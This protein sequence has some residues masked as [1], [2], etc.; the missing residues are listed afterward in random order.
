MKYINKTQAV[1][2]LKDGT[3]FYGKSIGISVQLLAKLPSI[4]EQQVI[5]K[6]LLILLILDKLWL[7]PMHIL[8]I[9]V[10]I[11]MKLNLI[12]ENCKSCL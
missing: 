3:I 1:L 5:K 12:E 7:Q 11:Q 10:L 9:M 4:L 8:V 2:L 6:S